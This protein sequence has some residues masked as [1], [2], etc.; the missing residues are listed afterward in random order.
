MVDTVRAARTSA[1]VMAA[2]LVASSAATLATF[3][4]VGSALPMRRELLAVALA[5]AL[6]AA[7][8]DALALRVRPQI[9]LQVPERWRRLLPLPLASFL[10]GAV[11]GTG[12]SSAM[13]AFAGWAIV[14]VAVATGRPG[15]AAVAGV[16]L[17]VGRA[18]PIVLGVEAAAH[19]R[20]LRLV[21][22]GCAGALALAVIGLAPSAAAAAPIGQAVDPSAAGGDLAWQQPGPGGFLLRAGAEPQ[23]LPGA[24]PAIGGGLIAWH[25]GDTVTVADRATLQPRFQERIVGARQLAVSDEWLVIR[26]VQPDGTWRLIV[27]SIADTNVHR[28]IAEARPPRTVGRPAV[29]GATVVYAV[30]SRRGSSIVA[31]SLPGGKA[32]TVRR[33][34]F[35][36]LLDPSVVGGA[37]LYDEVARCDQFLRLGP[38]SGAGGRVLYTLP[39]LAG[40]DSGRERGHTREGSRTPCRPPVEP[41]T[42]MLWTTALGGG[43]AYVTVL[44]EPQAGEIRS[45]VIAVRIPAA[46]GR[47]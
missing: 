37:L 29:D 33:S 35:D 4:L 30:S 10:Y 16:A 31:V 6:L 43:A 24:D 11:L 20:G 8:G 27:Q 17:G 15:T 25:D 18:L 40:Q 28:V 36:L 21:R 44:A 38:L 46:T 41:T 13:P 47:V 12:L 14:T 2:A 34:R 1:V 22:S 45:E 26:Q 42:R 32:S 3:A 7:V 23:R 19:P 39:P 9:P 5:L